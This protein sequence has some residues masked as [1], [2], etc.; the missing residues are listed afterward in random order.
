MMNEP[1]RIYK[2]EKGKMLQ[3]GA[4]GAAIV[5]KSI[6]FKAMDKVFSADVSVSAKKTISAGVSCVTSVN[7]QD[8]AVE[9]RVGRARPTTKKRSTK[10]S[11][12]EDSGAR[13]LGASQQH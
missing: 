8:I 2:L 5:S 4:P 7:S 6:Y 3:S 12:T 9:D 11:C 1:K 10:D 13:L